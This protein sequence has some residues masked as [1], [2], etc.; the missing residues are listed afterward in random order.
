MVHHNVVIMLSWWS[1]CG[2]TIDV[3]VQW[4]TADLLRATGWSLQSACTARCGWDGG[5]S[6]TLP[7]SC[8]LSHSLPLPICLLSLSLVTLVV[9]PHGWWLNVKRLQAYLLPLFNKVYSLPLSLSLL[10]P[11]SVCSLSLSLSLLSL[12]PSIPPRLPPPLP[13][14]SSS[15]ITSGAMAWCKKTSSLSTTLVQ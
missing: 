1:W 4:L 2:F 12:S 6:A 9:F 3:S 10:H 13:P 5:Q 7:S 14:C 15:S 11:L 8:S